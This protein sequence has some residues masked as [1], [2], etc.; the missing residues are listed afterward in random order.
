MCSQPPRDVNDDWRIQEMLNTIALIDSDTSELT[1]SGGEPTLLKDGF[2]KV[3]AT[4]KERLPNTALHVLSNGRLFRYGALAKRLGEIQHPDL[5]V[6]VPV[7]SDLDDRHD[8]VVQAKGAFEDTLVGLHNLGRHDVPVEIRV[9]LHRYTYDRL[10]QLAEFIYRNL[11][12]ASHVTFM[13][14]EMTGYTIANLDELWIDPWDYRDQLETATL[15]L[16]ARGI[17]VSVYNHQLC[18]VP[19]SIW[20]YCLKSISDW[21]NEYVA[22]CTDCGVRTECG[23]FF[24]SGVRRRYSAHILPVPTLATEIAHPR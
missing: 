8:H 22:E 18:T 1:I 15:Y 12:F 14:L 19:E 7:Y 9:V 10:P 6:G 11:T 17:R 3:I 2:L 21:K 13:G 24:T 20:R 23:G 16:A 4:A 5:M